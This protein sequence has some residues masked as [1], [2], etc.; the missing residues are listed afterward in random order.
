MSPGLHREFHVSRFAPG[1][2]Q[3]ITWQQKRQKLEQQKRQQQAQRLEQQQAQVQLEQQLLLFYRKQ[4]K[5]QQRS[6]QPKREICSF[7]K[8]LISY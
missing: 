8:K 4:P 5:Q 7:L 6:Q 2:V 3:A 1:N